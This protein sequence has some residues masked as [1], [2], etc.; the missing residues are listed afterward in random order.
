MS[1]SKIVGTSRFQNEQ[2]NSVGTCGIRHE[3]TW[4]M[5]AKCHGVGLHEEGMWCEGHLA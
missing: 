5:E 4:H 2:T 1:N 3:D